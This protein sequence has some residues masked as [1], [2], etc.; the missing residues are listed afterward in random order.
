MI[1]K[2]IFLRIIVTIQNR[3]KIEFVFV[4][5]NTILLLQ[6]EKIKTFSQ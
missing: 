5:F 2:L 4:Y 3:T 1:R 6:K